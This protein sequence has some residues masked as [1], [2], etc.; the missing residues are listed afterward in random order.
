MKTLKNHTIIYD[1]D[2]PLCV[3]YTSAFTSLNM[4]DEKGKLPYD[5]LSDEYK[6]IN[7]HKATNEIALIDKASN[8]VYYGIDSLLKILEHSFPLIGA[9]GRL[10]PIYFLLTKFYKFISFNRKVI[11]TTPQTERSCT[12]DFN[13][14]YRWFYIIFCVLTSSFILNHFSPLLSAYI[15]S[16]NFT[17]ELL[18]CGGQ[19]LFQGI[20]L[21]AFKKDNI[22]HYLGNMI[23]ISLMGSLAIIPLL[24]INT[25]ILEIAPIY[26]LIYFG[27]VILFMV[28][29][30]Q[31]RVT[32]L[33][34][35]KYLTLT[36][37][38]Y[39]MLWIPILMIQ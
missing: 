11:I 38:L 16:S 30:H 9:I 21:L 15:N 6:T 18:M 27:L 22:L 2:C 7:K 34:L 33:Q 25:Y 31:R 20:I 3:G 28:F 8:T 4:L 23:T 32:F 29:E 19:I 14:K 26:S 5:Q 39:R 1:S 35:P 17:R 36:W 13:I 10:S 12:P 24:I 37:I